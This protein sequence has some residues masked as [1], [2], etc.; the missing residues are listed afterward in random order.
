M[1]VERRALALQ[2]HWRIYNAMVNQ[3]EVQISLV[4]REHLGQ[5]LQFILKEMRALNIE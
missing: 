2:E 4:I 3:D 1:S 5:S